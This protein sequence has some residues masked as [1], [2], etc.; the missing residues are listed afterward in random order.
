MSSHTSTPQKPPP[1]SDAATI[2]TTD[3]GFE[4][5]VSGPEHPKAPDPGILIDDDLASIIEVDHDS[6]SGYDDGSIRSL[7]TSLGSLEFE[8][9]HEHGHR[10][11]G[12]DRVLLPNDESE[13][14][15]LDLQHHI[16]KMCLDGEITATDLPPTVQRIFDVGTGTGI[17]AI[18]MGDKYTSAQITGVD[19]SPIQPVWV[20]PNVSF[21]ID[22]VTRPWLRTKD[23]IDF[24][25]I[26]NM[27]GSIRDWKELF[28][29]ALEH[30]KPGG[31]IEVTD[32]RTQFEC[33]DDTFK[34]RGKACEA[35]KETFHGIA[36]GMGMDF[37]P[38]PKVPEW[39]QEVGFED[40]H[41]ESRIIPV[42]P[43]PKNKKLKAL[44]AY[45]LS[46]ML[47]GGMENY[48]M[49]LFTKAGW[50]ATSVHALLGKVRTELK[51]PGMHTFTRACFVT[52]RKSL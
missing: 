26:R 1:D 37:D 49:M 30:L 47:D 45:Y 6:D 43:W 48:S 34:E 10:Y 12:S 36:K 15:R 17:W 44:G 3:S 32:I 52:G 50:E 25:H 20:P 42:G 2:A 16:L 46:H 11:H 38:T 27:V 35:W 51:D 14:D 29:E 40:V 22:D 13:Q 9:I 4:S 24:I 33:L 41:L 7:T 39:L 28:S 5:G 19:I 8:H 31:R 18:E 21:E 23:S